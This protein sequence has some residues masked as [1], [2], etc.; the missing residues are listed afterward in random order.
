MPDVQLRI[1]MIFGGTFYPRGMVIEDQKI[2]PTLRRQKYIGE[3]GSVE[4][5]YPEE[6]S[7][8]PASDDEP[9]EENRL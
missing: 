8:L 2:P 7:G 6:E 3:P 1:N 9:S 5:L 4:P